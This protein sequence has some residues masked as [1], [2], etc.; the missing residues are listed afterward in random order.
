[1]KKCKY[2]DKPVFASEMCPT[3][4]FRVRRHGDPEHTVQTKQEI[5]V[6]NEKGYIALYKRDKTLAILAICDVE[7]IPRIKKHE[8]RYEANNNRIIDKKN[9]QML[10]RFILKIRKNAQSYVK[11]IFLNKDTSDFRKKNLRLVTQT[12]VSSK[13]IRKN[14]T[15][16]AKYIGV[17]MQDNHYYASI[18][19]KGKKIY[20]GAF[21]SPEFAARAYN[22]KAQELYGDLARLNKIESSI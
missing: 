17:W 15:R 18:G 20:L 3:H 4:Y 2:C 5:Y 16:K 12:I 7:D 9:K 6:E 8:W 10:A 13:Q 19:H 22:R 11:I 1:M 21:P 14:K